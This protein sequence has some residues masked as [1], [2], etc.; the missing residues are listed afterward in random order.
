VSEPQPEIVFTVIFGHLASLPSAGVPYPILVFVAVLPWQFFANALGETTNSLVGNSNLLSKVYFPRIIVPASTILVCFVD[1]LIAS[2]I[3]VGL[4]VWY[5][6]APDWRIVA[7]PVFIL[8]AVMSVFGIGLWLAILNVKYRDFRYVVPFIV[9][10]GLFVSPVGFSSAVVPDDWQRVYSLN[11]MVEV[12][13]GFRWSL[14]QGDG[15]VSPTS[16]AISAGMLAIMLMGGIWYFR[17]TE[18]T[19]ADVI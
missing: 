18:R 10:L 1:F 11:P 16:V 9:Q 6:V 19:F 2:L 3:L 14:L 7:L 13:E 17:K 15:V 8:L 4:F 5:G 12:I